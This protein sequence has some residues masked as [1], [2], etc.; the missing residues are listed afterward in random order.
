MMYAM[1]RSPADKSAPL[2]WS[3][4]A[5]SSPQKPRLDHDRIVRSAMRI[6]DQEGLGAISMRR[7][8]GDVNAGAMSLY[9]YVASKEELLDLML[10]AAYGEIVVPEKPAGDWRADL[11][12]LARQTRN[13]LKRHPWTAQLVT[14][15]PTLGPSYLRWFEFSL[16]AVT[17]V[18]VD[19][20]TAMRVIGT[21]NAYVS[22]VVAYELGDAEAR[23]RH[24]LSEP[25]MRA[26]VAPYLKQ[27]VASGRFPNLARFLREGRSTVSDDDFEFGLA[28]VLDGLAAALGQRRRRKRPKPRRGLKAR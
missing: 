3:R 13:V 25:Q 5:R 2:I 24:G 17:S 16:Q 10:D 12:G 8:A 6:A 27:L 1:S 20:Q 23:R 4:L 11:A 7:V 19:L 14:S 15:R 28:S 21:T 9:R 18:Q 22:G 26:L